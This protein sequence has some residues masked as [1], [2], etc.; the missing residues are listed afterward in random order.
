[1]TTILPDGEA[2]LF[3]APPA[4]TMPVPRQGASFS[5]Y[6][7]RGSPQTIVRHAER[8]SSAALGAGARRAFRD[9]AGSGKRSARLVT[10]PSVGCGDLFG[11]RTGRK[12]N[13][14]KSA[15]IWVGNLARFH[16]GWRCEV[17]TTADRA[18]G[19][20][21]LFRGATSN[22]EAYLRAVRP[23]VS[24][25]RKDYRRH[26]HATPNAKGQPRRELARRVRDSVLEFI[27][28]IQLLVRSHAA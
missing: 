24:I 27:L 7:A 18:D 3:G 4:A 26:S 28:G 9:D 19:E 8:Q 22:D 16:C 13:E 21:R 2:R 11:Q 12:P 10:D 17:E 25:A 1:M 14:L 20:A 23:P 15:G 6:S 5:L